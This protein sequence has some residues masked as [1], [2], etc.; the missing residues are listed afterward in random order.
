MSEKSPPLIS[1][2]MTTYNHQKYVEEAIQSILDQT[3]TDFELIIVN[4][5]STDNTDKIINKFISDS[6]VHYIS[7]ENQGTSLAINQ[8]ILQSKGKYI[9]LMSGDDIC[10]PNRLENQ[11][12]CL[13]EKQ[14]KVIFTW[15]DIIDDN[16]NFIQQNR[17]TEGLFNHENK[18]S[19]EILNYFFFHGNYLCAITALIE[20]AEI[21]KSG[22]FNLSLI[23]LQDFDMWTK[24]L[25]QNEIFILPLKL[26]KYRIRNNSGNLSSSANTLRVKFEM[27]QI[28]RHVLNDISIDLFKD[29]FHKDIKRKDFQDGIEYEI[30]K[31]FL[32]LKHQFPFIRSIGVEK[33]F[34]LLQD[35]LVLAVAK[36]KYNFSL[37]HLY[38]LTQDKYMINSQQFIS[39]KREIYWSIINSCLER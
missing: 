7:Q 3:F 10:Y 29:A 13:Q 24:L 36:E 31:A 39:S 8:G 20:R 1:V 15:V 14:V 23:Q 28:Y 19:A 6:K 26:A 30:E 5:G 32:Y 35:S 16:G 9:A 12:Q 11:Y 22:L 25:K 4:D 17:S 21:L 18:T 2:V 37:P 38:K 33:L 34:N 27:Y